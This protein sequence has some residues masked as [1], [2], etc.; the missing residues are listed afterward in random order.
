MSQVKLTADS[1]GGTVA[2]KG[3]ASTTGNAAIQLLLPVADGTSGQA[4]TTNGSGQL[5]FADVSGGKLLKVENFV[6]Q[7]TTSIS[8]V[9]DAYVATPITCSITPSAAS[10]KILVM[11]SLA[12]GPSDGVRGGTALYRNINSGGFSIVSGLQA[13]ALGSNQRGSGITNGATQWTPAQNSNSF[14]DTPSYSVG[15]AIEYKIYMWAE[16]STAVYINRIYA[17]DSGN[18]NYGVGCSTI[19][20]MEVA[21]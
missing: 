18:A 16:T 7:G 12:V 11:Y 20:L 4:L 19:T 3:P 6:Y 9:N 8:S 10:S 2:I 13:T 1:G 17:N 5:A 21:A 15:N 14:L